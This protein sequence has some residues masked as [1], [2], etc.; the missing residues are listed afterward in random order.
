MSTK[1]IF[2]TRTEL[3]FETQKLIWLRNKLTDNP[4]DSDLEYYLVIL[5]RAK[6]L[7]DKLLNLLRRK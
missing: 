1:T 2:E 3:H 4:T 7:E 6:N 5:N